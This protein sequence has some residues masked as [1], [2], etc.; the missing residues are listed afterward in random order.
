[1]KKFYTAALAIVAGAVMN[2]T[3]QRAPGTIVPSQ[4]PKKISKDLFGIFFED[5]SYA[6]DGGLYAELVQNRS[7]EYGPGDNN[8]FTPFTAWDFLTMRKYGYGNITVETNAPLSENNPHYV[9]LDIQ[10]TGQQGMGIMNSGFD[11]IPVKSGEK[12]DVSLF[13][14][15]LSK[16]P[17]PIK[18]LL[19]GKK[20]DIYGAVEFNTELGNWK[21]Y[22][23]TITATQ[24][25]DSARLVVLAMTKGRLAL[26]E[27]SLF[28]QNT[29][30]GRANG[31]RADLAQAI[32]DLKP[33]FMRFP[34][35]CLTHGDGL[36]NI[37]RWKN[38]IGPV[39]QRVQMRNIWRYHQSMGLGFYEYFQFCEDIGA[40]PLPVLAA[41]VSCQNT[42][43]TRET[44]QEALPM[45][46][47]KAYIQDVCDLIEFANGPV[48]STWGA[49][50]AAAGH[51]KPFDL[52]YV[53]IGNEDKI[54]PQFK[55]RYEMITKAVRAKYPNITLVGTVGPRPSGEDF[56]LGWQ[57]AIGLKIPVVDEH[58][59]EKPDFFLTNNQRYDTYDRSHPEVYIGE[60]ASWGNTLF[61]ALSEASYMTGL[62]RNGDVVRMASY[63]PLI[64]R[65]GHISWNPNLIYF[66]GTQVVP[67]VNYYVQKLFSSNQGDT[68][69]PGV[70]KF[71]DNPASKD[72]ILASSCVRDS[73]SGDIILKIVNVGAAGAT[74]K[75]DLSRF[76]I[77]KSPASL[78]LISGKPG[79][80][81]TFADPNAVVPKNST[82]QVGKEL[83]YQ[84]PPFSLSVIRIHTKK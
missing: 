4:M 23:R 48:T 78:E 19:Q 61:N 71:K 60:Y 7:F 26:D 47:M 35:G 42:G 59:Y 74:A 82:I 79:E 84:A 41:A 30:K 1:M 44:G 15:V 11:G 50:R 77:T 16:T 72:S 27:I 5:L 53:G 12:Y 28:P 76:S 68:Y 73:G 2:A 33:K 37:Y 22:N 20:G 29:F 25:N 39:E 63:A 80:K 66:T 83:V 32:A 62:E 31:M 6:A 46:E 55:E 18:V 70:V 57:E 81:D 54:T 38:T 9:V 69:Y 34:G 36:E 45:E 64:A 13:A 10:G 52:Q 75:A 3:A 24:T 21:K 43:G 67:T 58:Y 56:E 51:P 49:K 65:Q 17:I 8:A 14:R 40:K